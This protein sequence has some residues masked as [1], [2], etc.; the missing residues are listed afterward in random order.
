MSEFGLIVKLLKE[1][2]LALKRVM[3]RVFVEDREER[4]LFFNLRPSH[5]NRQTAGGSR[6]Q[7]RGV[8]EFQHFPR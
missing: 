4:V 8:G 1:R 2:R 3:K 5:L 7:T 6:I